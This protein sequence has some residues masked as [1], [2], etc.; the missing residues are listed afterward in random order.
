MSTF[1]KVVCRFLE[2]PIT[3]WQ[4]AGN[5]TDLPGMHSCLTIYFLQAESCVLSKGNDLEAVGFNGRA[6]AVYSST[7]RR[8]Q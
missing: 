4:T 1:Q 5:Q 8:P 3:D 7:V 6:L 2:V